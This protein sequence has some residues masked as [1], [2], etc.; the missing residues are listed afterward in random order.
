MAAGG[1][2]EEVVVMM[3]GEGT[4]AEQARKETSEKKGDQWRWHGIATLL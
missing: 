4:G 3:G 2:E 1:E